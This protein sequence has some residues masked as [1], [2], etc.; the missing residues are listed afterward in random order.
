MFTWIIRLK[1]ACLTA[2]LSPII[3]I[4]NN[5]CFKQ[6]Q[7]TTTTNIN[8]TAIQTFTTHL[9]RNGAASG[10][11]AGFWSARLRFFALSRAISNFDSF[12]CGCSSSPGTAAYV[13]I[14]IYMCELLFS[15]IYSIQTN[16][17]STCLHCCYVS[18]CQISFLSNKQCFFQPPTSTTFWACCTFS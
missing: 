8:T 12:F 9:P 6:Q 10:L 5:L 16:S 3:F 14:Y 1:Q 18:N 13:F 11:L 2:S 7:T 17:F 15:I 4:F